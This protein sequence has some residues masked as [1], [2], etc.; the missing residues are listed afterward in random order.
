MRA[1]LSVMDQDN[2]QELIKKWKSKKGLA[3]DKFYFHPYIKGIAEFR[4]TELSDEDDSDDDVACNEVIT[5]AKEQQ[6]RLL[7]VHQTA[8]QS[9]L[10]SRYGQ[11]LAF[12]DATYKTTKYSL[13]LFFIVVKTNVDYIIVVSVIGQDETTASITEALSILCQW[14]PQW[15]LQHMGN[16]KRHRCY[17][18]RILLDKLLVNVCSES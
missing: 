7:L 15:K 18:C 6:G 16:S 10:L 4:N 5:T 8:W 17:M 12:L 11:E 2:V 3:S 1:R 13:P 9:R 14:N